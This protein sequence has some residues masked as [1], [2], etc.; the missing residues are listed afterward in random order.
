M[1]KLIEN[2]SGDYRVLRVCFATSDPLKT[3]DDLHHTYS[4]KRFI[5]FLE[6]ADAKATIDEDAAS[7]TRRKAEQA[8]AEAQKKQNK[9]V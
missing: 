7:K 3:L 2:F 1:K 8:Q 9:G 6:Y 4:Y 5:Q